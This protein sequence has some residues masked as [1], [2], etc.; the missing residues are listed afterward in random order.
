MVAFLLGAS[1]EVVY[2]FY[3][4]N[5]Q[6]YTPHITKIPDSMRGLFHTNENF[7][8]NITPQTNSTKI[9]TITS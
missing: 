4:C 5:G 2:K 9:S 8:I 1:E 7:N 3:D 6:E